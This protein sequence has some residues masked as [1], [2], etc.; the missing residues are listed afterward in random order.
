MPNVKA[1]QVRKGQVL[2]IDGGLFVVTDHEFRKPGKGSSFNQIKCKQMHTGTFKSMRLSTDEVV[3]VAFLET[4][5]C[6]YSY[7]EG[8]KFV[9]MDKEN[10]E[11]YFLGAD[12]VGDKM[13][14]VRDNQEVNVTFYEGAALSLELPTH[15]I[16]QITEAEFSA[17][18]DSV[19]NDKKGAVCETGLAVR[20]PTY[21]V[22]G[23]WIKVQTD[24][25]DFLGRAE[26]PGA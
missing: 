6:N 11:Q 3:E 23:E 13:K 2:V 12:L 14:F 10:Y 25:G 5:P 7:A 18:G 17:K 22:S 9:F 24:S 16:L 19:T 15:V 26:D 21:I 20:V 4:R 8:D 1:N